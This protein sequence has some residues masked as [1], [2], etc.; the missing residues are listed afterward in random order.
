[1][2]INNILFWFITV[3]SIYHLGLDLALLWIE[4]R[5][6]TIAHPWLRGAWKENKQEEEDWGFPHSTLSPGPSKVSVFFWVPFSSGNPI[7]FQSPFKLYLIFP[8]R[9]YSWRILLRLHRHADPRRLAWS[10]VW[11]HAGVRDLSRDR[12]CP[13]HAN[14]NSSAN[15]CGSFDYSQGDRGADFGKFPKIVTLSD[16]GKKAA[17]DYINQ[18]FVMF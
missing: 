18:F 9:H 8:T 1:M 5:W 7:H 15:K 6:Y 4:T 14:A 10:A 17:S 3:F 16:E 2:K 13:D 11:R 12:F